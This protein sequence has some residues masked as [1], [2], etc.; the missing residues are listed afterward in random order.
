M[1]IDAEFLLKTMLQVTYV[2]KK[3]K[4]VFEV[5]VRIKCLYKACYAWSLE[6]NTESISLYSLFY[7]ELLETDF[8]TVSIHENNIK[9]IDL[10]VCCRII[11][12]LNRAQRGGLIKPFNKTIIY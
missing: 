2:R 5:T 12:H 7:Y 6:P 9:M 11:Y 10:N 1:K 4:N 8:Y 3:V